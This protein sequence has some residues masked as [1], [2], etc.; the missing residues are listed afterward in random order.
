M[1][2]DLSE[3]FLLD[4]GWFMQKELLSM[5]LAVNKLQLKKLKTVT[6]GALRHSQTASNELKNAPTVLHVIQPFAR[7]QYMYLQGHLVKIVQGGVT[8]RCCYAI[9]HKNDLYHFSRQS[10]DILQDGQQP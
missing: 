1:H 4:F 7:I 8:F 3:P 6:G 5:L 9:I 2:D 10:L